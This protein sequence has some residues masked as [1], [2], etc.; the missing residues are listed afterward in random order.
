MNDTTASPCPKCARLA[1]RLTLDDGRRVDCCEH[2]GWVQPV[3]A[4][5]PPLDPEALA[6]LTRIAEDRAHSEPALSRQLLQIAAAL[7]EREAEKCK[8]AWEAALLEATRQNER[9]DALEAERDRLR[10]FAEWATEPSGP[11]DRDPFVHAENTINEVS[12][13]ACAVLN[14][15]TTAG[16]NDD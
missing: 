13:R 12:R 15:L 6:E 8:I 16:G 5:R 7:R 1:G 4:G 2:C 3:D 14:A 11:F 10:E 9:A